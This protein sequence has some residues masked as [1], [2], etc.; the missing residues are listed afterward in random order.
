MGVGCIDYL[1][2]DPIVVP[3][4]HRPY[5][6]EE[7][8]YLPD[9]YQCNDSNRRVTKR[10]PTRVE[11]GLP[12]GFVFC[13]FNNNHK[14]TPEIFDTWM[15]LL[16]ALEGSV[17]WLLKDNPAVAANLRREAATRGIVPDRL[18]FAARTDPATHLARQ[19]LADLFLDTLP[20]NAHTTASDA[21]WVGLPVLTLIGSTFAGRVA[22]SVLQAVDLPE[23]VTTS[24]GEYEALALKLARE[25]GQLA[26]IKAKL[27][28][29]RDRCALFD[30]PRMTRSLE[31]AYTQMWERTQRGLPPATFGAQGFLSP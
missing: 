11:V 20:Y 2:A 15:R 22:A 10:I 30:T 9:T 16:G 7:I 19:G 14:I 21:L 26:A 1:I 24:L 31:A 23:L 27:R 25:P 29:N 18:V 3:D 6:A 8:A 4:A 17:L 12:S 28:A 13:C 5:Y